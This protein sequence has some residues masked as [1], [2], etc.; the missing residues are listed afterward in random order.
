MATLFTGAGG[1]LAQLVVSKERS[2]PLYGCALEHHEAHYGGVSG[3]EE[4]YAALT[5]RFLI[6]VPELDAT[7]LAK[8]CSAG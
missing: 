1:T 2:N 5:S 7:S 3:A 6:E 4:R 8:A